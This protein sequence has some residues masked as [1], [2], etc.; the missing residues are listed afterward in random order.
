M[1]SWERIEQRLK[2]VEEQI[3]LIR[4]D[5]QDYKPRVWESYYEHGMGSDES[6]APYP[7]YVRIEK[8]GT[9]HET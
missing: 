5:L 3:E 1:Q 2:M 7:K 8:R 4:Q 6:V 9:N